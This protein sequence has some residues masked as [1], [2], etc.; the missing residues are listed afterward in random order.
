MTLPNDLATTM[1]R[2][3]RDAREPRPGLALRRAESKAQALARGSKGGAGARGGNPHRQR[4]GVDAA[5][6]KG[7]GTAL[8]DRLL[9][10][11][12]QLEGIAKDLE[13]IGACPTRSAR[14]CDERTRPNG[15]KITRVAVPLGVIGIIYESR[16]NVTA[17]PARSRSDQEMPRSCAAGRKVFIRRG[18]SSRPSP[19]GCALRDSPRRQSSWCPRPTATQSDDARDGE[20][21]IIVP[22]GASRNRGSSER[23]DP[24]HRAPRRAVS[25]LC[26]Y[27][28]RSRKGARDRRQRQ[29]APRLDLRRADT[30]HRPRC[31]AQLT[32]DPRRPTQRRMRDPRR[33][34]DAGHRL[35]RIPASEEDGP[36]NI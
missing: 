11:P 4:G 21:D 13:D 26:R 19:T 32:G 16:P 3:G 22:R 29:D 31:K 6:S 18:P 36:K 1:A 5:K 9:L 14:G 25:H 20:I 33:R 12:K 28:R 15:L 24:G 35:R 27:R 10:D 2:L 8:V 34:R 17:A 23:A 7:I 30:A